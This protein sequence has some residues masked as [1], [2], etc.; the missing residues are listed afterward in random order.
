MIELIHEELNLFFRKHSDL[1]FHNCFCV[2]E[3]HPSSFLKL[4]YDRYKTKVK[5][6]FKF[7]R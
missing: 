4:F 5:I 6:I 7:S 2:I 3:P 1:D